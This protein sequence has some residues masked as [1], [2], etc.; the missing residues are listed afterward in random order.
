MGIIK[1]AMMAG[2]GIYAVNKIAQT[3]QNNQNRRSSPQPQQQYVDQGASY[4]RQQQQQQP[5]RPMEFSNSRGQPQQ[6]NGQSQHL[7]TNDADA[8]VPV[9]GYNAEGGYYY[10]ITPRGDPKRNSAQM[11]YANRASSPPRYEYQEQRERGFVE[12]EEYDN[13]AGRSGSGAMLTNLM[14][15]V[16]RGKGGKGKDLMAKFMK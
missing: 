14:H 15:G 6:G 9:Y 12:S 7:L 5:A 4:Q 2:A 8:P 16:G 11:A 10:E 1:T 3:A 13:G